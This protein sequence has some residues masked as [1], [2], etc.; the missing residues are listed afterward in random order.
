M[1][2][3]CFITVWN[4]YGKIS[5]M[6]WYPLCNDTSQHRFIFDA[7]IVLVWENLWKCLWSL[8]AGYILSTAFGGYGDSS[9]SK[10]SSMP[11]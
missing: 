2:V 6:F 11:V 8:S 10:I 4:E 1:E 7:F 9:V 5:T 3:Q